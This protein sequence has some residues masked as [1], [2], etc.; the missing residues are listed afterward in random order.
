MPNHLKQETSPYL[1]QHADNPVDWYAWG[2]EAF[3]RAKSADCPILVSIGYAAC[4][5]CHVMAHECFED[6]EVAKHLNESFVS[7]KIDREERPDIDNFYMDALHA[8]GESGGWPLTVFTDPDGIPIFA[9]T[10]FPKHAR[11]GRPGFLD[12]LE[13]IKKAWN[14]DRDKIHNNGKI[15]LDHLRNRHHLGDE[16]SSTDTHTLS[17][18]LPTLLKI[19]DT[20]HG[21]IGGAPKFPNAPFLDCLWSGAVD[22]NNDT[23]KNAFLKTMQALCTGG[24]YDHIGGGLARYSVDEKWLVPHF[25]KMLYDN[26][27]FIRHL[28]MAYR[29]SGNE[30]YRSRLLESV[31]WLQHTMLKNG[32]LCA[33]LDADS[34]GEEGKYY[35]WQHEEVLKI[36]GSDAEK[37]TDAYDITPIGNWESSCIPNL[38]HIPFDSVLDIVE[39]HR[40]ERE[41]LLSVRAR[42]NPPA[43]DDKI[44]SEWNGYMI[45]ALAQASD[46]APELL[47]F[48]QSVFSSVCETNV[49]DNEIIRCGTSKNSFSAMASDRTAMVNASLTLLERTGETDYLTFAL[50]HGESLYA[51]HCDPDGALYQSDKNHNDLPIRLLALHDDPNP[52]AAAQMIRLSMRLYLLSGEMKWYD[53]AHNI[54][55]FQQSYFSGSSSAPGGFLSVMEWIVNPQLICIITPQQ[56]KEKELNSWKKC[57][58]DYP[59][60]ARIVRIVHDSSQLPPTSKLPEKL[61]RGTNKTITALI[62]GAQTCSAPIT[63]ID[64]FAKTLS[65]H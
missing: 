32:A 18:F 6:E 65:I 15:L 59:H 14:E 64:S 23:A 12:I 45:D 1:R 60:S 28:C 16:P 8:T 17:A 34:D 11:Y 62:C 42:R 46:I 51:N 30:L 38:L 4:H 40:L 3:T 10:Y 19:Q 22:Y 2:E 26:A 48:S 21:G 53:R 49:L 63:D 37:F 5:W 7:V 55:E 41:K 47:P 24:I 36:L 27:H 25:E 13:A 58:W 57:L 29:G 56:S 9:G 50:H 33:S 54:A 43:R 39:T 44:L 20:Q 52:S 31:S 61:L 35:V